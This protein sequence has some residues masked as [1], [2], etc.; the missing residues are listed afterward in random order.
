MLN[1]KVIVLGSLSQSDREFIIKCDRIRYEH[2]S[3]IFEQQVLL[4]GWITVM[5]V[6]QIASIV[7]LKTLD[8]SL[9]E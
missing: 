9:N 2:H 8:L 5:T 1:Y 6:P 4:L 3:I 7:E